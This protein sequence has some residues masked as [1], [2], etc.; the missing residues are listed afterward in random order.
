MDQVKFF[1]D[2][3]PQILLGPF[4]NTFTRLFLL[5]LLKLEVKI[6]RKLLYFLW[7]NSFS[8]RVKIFEKLTFLAPLIRTHTCA[9][10]GV[11]N[12]SFSKNFAYVLN[13]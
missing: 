8:S 1:E 9:C 13:E 10:Q 3:L 6:A 11:R 2:C 12:I 7:D 4:L 5:F